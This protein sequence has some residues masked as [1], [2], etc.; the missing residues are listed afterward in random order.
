ME[1]I[2]PLVIDHFESCFLAKSYVIVIRNGTVKM[3]RISQK[4]NKKN[5]RMREASPKIRL[6]RL[7][8]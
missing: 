4:Q 5:Q 6:P 3:G 8:Y 1:E 2:Y 7:Y